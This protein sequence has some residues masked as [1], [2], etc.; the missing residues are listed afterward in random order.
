MFDT[1]NREQEAVYLAAYI[2]YIEKGRVLL[3]ITA[4]EPS[5]H[6]SPA[7]STLRAAGVPVNYLHNRG[8]YA[9][10]LVLGSPDKTVFEKE[11]DSAADPNAKL[12]IIISRKWK[13]MCHST[14]CISRD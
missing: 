7:L 9:F 5:V 10:A 14:H 4:G 3:G 11:L 6:I 8:S 13:T 1:Q 12:N 2:A